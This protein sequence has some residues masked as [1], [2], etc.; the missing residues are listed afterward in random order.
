MSFPKIF[1]IWSDR[2]RLELGIC[3]PFW[4]ISFLVASPYC[5]SGLFRKANPPRT[6]SDE[7]VRLIFVSLS[8]YLFLVDLR[9]ER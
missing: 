8:F 3:F 1:N 4:Y 2:G 5:F 6:G 9:K 7:P